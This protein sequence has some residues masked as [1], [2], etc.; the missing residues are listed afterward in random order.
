M[1]NDNSAKARISS[2]C[3]DIFDI[4][5]HSTMMAKEKAIFCLKL[6]GYIFFLIKN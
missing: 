3:K 5:K 1:K 4:A 6:F 2:L